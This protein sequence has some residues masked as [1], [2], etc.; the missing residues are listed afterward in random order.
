TGQKQIVAA[1]R[2]KDT[3]SAGA[4]LYIL[5]PTTGTTVWSNANLFSQFGI[6]LGLRIVDLNGDGHPKIV[7]SGLDMAIIDGGTH[8][9]THIPGTVYYGF[10]IVDADGDGTLDIVAGS[11]AV[12]G[13]N[14]ADQGHIVVLRGP[15]WTKFVDIKV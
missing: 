2:F 9:I 10:D 15:S 3:R 5:D 4:G 7:A 6:I 1:T 8:Q 12:N 13:G 11:G 14:A